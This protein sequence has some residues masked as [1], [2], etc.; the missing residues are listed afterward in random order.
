MLS[1]L[2]VGAGG[3]IAFATAIVIATRVARG[4]RARIFA[5]LYVAAYLAF[6]VPSLAIGFIAARSSLAAGFA[7][8]IVLLAALVAALP[9]LR[10]K[11]K[12]QA[13]TG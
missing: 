11:A 1:T 3:G 12:L 7:V 6:A 13:V 9:L 10:A 2:L 5:R 4:Q 8:V